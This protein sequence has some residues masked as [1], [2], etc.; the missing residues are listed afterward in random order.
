[1]YKGGL[2]KPAG[3]GMYLVGSYSGSLGLESRWWARWAWG[4][5]GTVTGQGALWKRPRLAPRIWPGRPWTWTSGRKT[6][7][8]LGLAC[9]QVGCWKR[10]EGRKRSGLWHHPAEEALFNSLWG[11]IEPRVVLQEVAVTRGLC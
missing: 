7:K 3:P 5:G 2:L 11:V 1:M 6:K 4:E 10:R 8:P 9:Q